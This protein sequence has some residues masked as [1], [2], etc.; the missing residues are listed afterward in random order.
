MSQ[1]LD[2]ESDQKLKLLTD[3]LRAGP[4]SPEWRLAIEELRLS[5]G[6]PVE[7]ERQLL[8]RVREDLASGRAY[9]EIRPGPNFTRKVIDGIEQEANRPRRSP[10][11]ATFIALSAALMLVG[12]VA[13]VVFLV[14]PHP[15]LA[16]ALPDLAHSVFVDT[17]E[18]ASFEEA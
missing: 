2:F 6:Q 18:S 13:I 11:T 5:N 15:P 7:D 12:V 14:W 16:P 17:I 3:A 10:P 1:S 9:K 4:G 8:L